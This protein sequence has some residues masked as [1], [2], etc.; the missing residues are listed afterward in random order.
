MKVLYFKR[1]FSYKQ[2]SFSVSII[3]PVYYAQLVFEDIQCNITKQKKL[4]PH[5]PSPSMNVAARLRP[6]EI[7][8]LLS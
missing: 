6:I 1:T 7:I 3:P 5:R 4:R 8:V 2:T